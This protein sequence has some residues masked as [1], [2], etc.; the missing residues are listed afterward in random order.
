MNIYSYN[1]NGI[2]AAMQK[3]LMDWTNSKK[4][5]VLCLQEI[6]ALES[7]IDTESLQKNG[8]KYNYFFSAK[9]KG[10]SGVGILSKHIPKNIQIG[11]GIKHIDEEGRLIRIDFDSFSIISLYIPSG[12]NINRLSFKI[13]FCTIFLN[14]I[15]EL[16]K[17]IPNLI[18]L[19]D[20]NI[21]HQPIDIYDPI[22]NRNVSGFLPI[23]REWLSTFIEKCEMIDSFRI[24]NKKSGY[25]S[26]W[27]YRTKA[28]DTNKG[29]RIDYAM[30]SKSLTSKIKNAGISCE[31]KHSDHC[32]I[33]ISIQ[34]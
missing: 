19:G 3:K 4:I 1:V 31:A 9:K 7:Q 17:N 5:D 28:R 26:W 22:A 6:K 33:W 27:S 30:V 24:F 16:K 14:Y 10:Y 32:P 12:T 34:K 21:C 11:T 20:Y 2:R 25:Y 29:W 13:E 8:F 15:Q 18:I 23:E